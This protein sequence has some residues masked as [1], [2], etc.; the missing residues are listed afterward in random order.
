MPCCMSLPLA[1]RRTSSFS[2]PS[3]KWAP[4]RIIGTILNRVQEGAIPMTSYYKHYYG[5]V[6]DA[7]S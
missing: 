6:K 1:R 5:S 3:L 7:S 4:D 2:A